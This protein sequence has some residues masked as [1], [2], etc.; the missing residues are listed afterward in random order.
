VSATPEPFAQLVKRLAKE[1]GVPVN[2]VGL[3]AWN[4]EI[5]GTKPDTFRSVMAGRRPVTIVLA[6]AVAGVLGVP[7]EDFGE[8]RLAVLRRQL[9]EREVGLEQALTMLAEIEEALGYGGH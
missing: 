7:P 3:R 4:P 6:E 2:E 9:D 8:Y 5:K 1:R